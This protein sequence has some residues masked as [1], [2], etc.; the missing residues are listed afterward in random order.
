MKKYILF[1]VLL[2]FISCEQFNEVK[3]VESIANITTN[4]TIST[5]N[6]DNDIPKP[7]SFT[8]KFINYEDKYEVVKTTDASGNVSVNDIIP[9]IY[10]ITAS[11]EIADKG[12]T[13]FFNGTLANE[14]I[15]E[16]NKS[17]TINMSASKAGS[18]ILKEIYYNGSVGYYFRDQFYEIYNNGDETQYVD[19]LCLGILQ[20]TLATTTSYLWIVPEGNPEDYAFF[21]VTWQVPLFG[22]GKNYP[23]EPGESIIIAQNALNHN[24]PNRNPGNSL[25]LTGAEFETFIYDQTVN[26]DN[27]DA[28]NMELVFGTT[29]GTQWL[30]SVFGCAYAIFYPEGEID[31]NT[32]V[33]PE[34]SSTKAK[35]IP[36]DWVVD[37]VE[38][39]N[40]ETRITWKRMPTSIDAG[41]TFTGETYQGKSVSRRIKETTED[42]RV[43]YW[44]TNNSS[45]DFQVNPKAEAHRN[46][47]KI[48]S[49]NYWAN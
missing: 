22:D 35:E 13:Y 26:P 36:I 43:I 8:V 6:I 1:A 39:V 38:L 9:G 24:G 41:A 20:P 33:Q 14:I 18:L 40:N 23:L 15:T 17:L 32:W 21:G 45:E 7:E 10:S 49:W 30:A 12:F 47:A 19:G 5:S 34:G 29:F 3:D 2:A 27:P 25:D 44:D 28:I 48:P 31:P 46:G 16:N 4:V 11:G 42:G 37:G